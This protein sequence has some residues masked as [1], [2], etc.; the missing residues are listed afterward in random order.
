MH[1]IQISLALGR[2]RLPESAGY[3]RP[4]ITRPWANVRDD[5]VTNARNS[6]M[7]IQC[8]TERSQLW[9]HC[10]LQDTLR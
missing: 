8:S 1:L 4:H 2:R 7:K 5:A 10:Y 6:L 9:I 3:S